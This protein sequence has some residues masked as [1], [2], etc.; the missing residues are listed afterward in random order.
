MKIVRKNRIFSKKIEN[1]S[2]RFF[3]FSYIFQ[4]KF[5]K[6][7]DR[8]ILVLKKKVPGGRL[9]RRYLREVC[10]LWVGTGSV[11]KF[12]TSSFQRTAAHLPVPILSIYPAP[13]V[14]TK[15]TKWEYSQQVA[16]PPVWDLESHTKKLERKKF[17]FFHYHS[18]FLKLK[19]GILGKYMK[20]PWNQWKII[21]I[22]ENSDI[23]PNSRFSTSKKKW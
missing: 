5:S 12:T 18:F 10:E 16:L 9:F 17:L 3:S 8:K 14:K 6:F 15:Y 2:S 13:N 22:N 4:W 1:F 7:W 11:V 23:S 20:I 21:R 19:T